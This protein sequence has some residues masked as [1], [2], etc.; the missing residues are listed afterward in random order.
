MSRYGRVVLAVGSL[1]VAAGCGH[2]ET[3]QAM[4]R[5][6][7]QPTG[8]TVELYIAEQPLPARPFYEIA[9]VQAVG[10]GNE[11]H[12]EDVARALTEKA[13]RLGCDAVLRTFI[14][15]GY[16]R[17]HATVFCVKWL[18]PGPAAPSPVLPPDRGANPSPPKVRPAPAPR[19]EPLP[20]AGPGQGGGR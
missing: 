10:F 6:P 11:A 7:E 15:Q 8:R 5:A 17:A 14:D 20:S 16:S 3:H 1:L 9:L 12:P 4:L 18:G 2:T 13:G 19:I